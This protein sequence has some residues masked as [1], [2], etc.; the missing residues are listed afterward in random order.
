V[1]SANGSREASLFERHER[2]VNRARPIA[3]DLIGSLT[4]ARRRASKGLED[5]LTGPAGAGSRLF[6]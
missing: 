3:I 6:S 4:T 5:A 1:L 2:P